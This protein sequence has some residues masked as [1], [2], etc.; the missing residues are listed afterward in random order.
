MILHGKFRSPHRLFPLALGLAAIV[1]MLSSIDGGLFQDDLVHR[2][3]LLKGRVLPERYY[4]TPLL[5]SDAGTFT[6]ALRDT[7]AVTRSREDVSRLKE[8]GLFPWWASDDLRISNWRPLTAL[9]HWL[10]YQLFP[11]S[12]ALMHVHNLL[13]FGAVVAAVTVFYRRMMGVVPAAALAALLYVIDESNYFPVWWVANRNLLL[14]LFFSI[15]ALLCHDRWR[16]HG[17]RDCGVMA[18]LLLLGALL[19]TEAGIA[20]FAYLCA[21]A[22]VIDR[23]TRLRR[24]LS[25]VPAVVVIA[26]WRIGYNALGHGASG[27]GFV[28]DPGRE[29]LAYTLAVLERGPLLLMG[30]WAPLPADAYWMMSEYAM[31]RYLVPVYAFLALVFVGMLGLLRRDR[32][33]RFW[34]TGMLLC[35]LP[36]CATVPMNRNLLFVAIGAFGLLARYV[37]GMFAGSRWV[38]GR[39]IYRVP[40]WMICI[41]LLFIHV[42]VALGGRLW[43]R[44]M[45]AFSGEVICSTVEIGEAPNLSDKTVVLVNAPNP[46]LFVAMPHLRSYENESVPALARVLAPGWQPLKV[47]RTGESRLVIQSMKG[48]LLSVDESSTDMRPNFLYLY[49]TFNT[50]FRGQDE[51]FYAGQEVEFPDLAV[52]VLSVDDAGSPTAIQFDFSRSLDSSSLYHLQWHW[53]PMGLGSYSPFTIPAVGETT[54][55]PGPF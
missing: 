4:G 37:T 32:V 50:L 26:G 1:M 15:L 38:P 36:V 29:P 47:T 2:A 41:V 40:L 46:F 21:Y 52:E 12:P 54:V 14:A 48:S 31:G 53:K 42:P 49:R 20:T 55:I 34:F 44:R 7:F 6:G 27:G 30:Q 51:P 13:W 11:D 33:S 17:R 8:S 16:Q 23:D 45:F 25:L 35:V 19:S 5:P 39:R 28:I 9:T 10:D 3:H 24:A 18:P 22:V 43:S